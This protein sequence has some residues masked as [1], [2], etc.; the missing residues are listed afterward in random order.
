MIG[1]ESTAKP[2]NFNFGSTATQF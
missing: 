2:E 1:I